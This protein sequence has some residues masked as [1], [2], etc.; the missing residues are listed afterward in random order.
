MGRTL[1]T[2]NQLILNEIDNFR[3]FRRALRAEDQK[4][5]D[6][7]F[8]AARQHTAAISL[9]DHALPLESMLLAM[10]LEQQRRIDR[11]EM[12]LNGE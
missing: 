9:A 8:A 6:A 3:N 7:L 12:Q 10:L 5:F 1:A 4:L 2:T 11:L